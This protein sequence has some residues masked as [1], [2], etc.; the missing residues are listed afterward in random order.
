[1]GWFSNDSEDK[2]A[3][4]NQGQEDGSKASLP[5]QFMHNNFFPSLG[6]SEAYDKGYENGVANQ[7]E[8]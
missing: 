7:P 8:D 6:A 1:M 4:H 2:Q 3:E 5:E